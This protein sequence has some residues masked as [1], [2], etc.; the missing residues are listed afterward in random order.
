MPESGMLWQWRDIV[1]NQRCSHGPRWNLQVEEPEADETEEEEEQVFP[2]SLEFVVNDGFE[3]SKLSGC[4]QQRVP[5]EVEGTLPTKGEG[6]RRQEMC[7][8]FRQNKMEVV[9]CPC[10][11]TRPA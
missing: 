1:K 2:S 10:A 4:F 7:V 8:G 3:C 11:V 9:T 5:R 6:P